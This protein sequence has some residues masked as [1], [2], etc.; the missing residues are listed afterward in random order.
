MSISHPLFDALFDAP[1]LLRPSSKPINTVDISQ[2]V[3][4]HSFQLFP[5]IF[6]EDLRDYGS[7]QSVLTKNG[8]VSWLPTQNGYGYKFGGTTSDYMTTGDIGTQPPQVWSMELIVQV[9]TTTDQFL[10]GYAELPMSSTTDRR[11]YLNAS[12]ALQVQLYDGTDSVASWGTVTS[13]RIYHI[14][15][16]TDGANLHITANGVSSA[17]E[18][19][20]DGGYSGYSTPEFILG[21]GYVYPTPA[22]GTNANILYCNVHS[23]YIPPGTAQQYTTSSLDR[24]LK[25]KSATVIPIPV[26]AGGGTTLPVFINHYRNQGIM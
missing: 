24:I 23:K 8:T 22:S 6:A 19:V 20:A 4:N 1:E 26:A 10:C 9:N 17:V 16:A 2:E 11:I 5:F 12:G 13:G 14:I 25:P 3:A 15:A 18:A 7:V 21:A